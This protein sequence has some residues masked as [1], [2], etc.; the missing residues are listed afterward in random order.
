MELTAEKL[1]NE[2]RIEEMLSNAVGKKE[3]GLK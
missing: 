1:E 3:R 2:G